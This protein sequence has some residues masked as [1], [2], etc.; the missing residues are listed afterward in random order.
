MNLS[1]SSEDD[2]SMSSSDEGEVIVNN[3]NNNGPKS[4]LLT[5][6]LFKQETKTKPIT[7]KLPQDPPSSRRR[8][9]IFSERLIQPI[10]I[11]LNVQER[12]TSSNTPTSTSTTTTTTTTFQKKTLKQL[13]NNNDEKKSDNTTCL[14]TFHLSLTEASNQM[15]GVEQQVGDKLPHSLY[16]QYLLLHA[17]QPSAY[18]STLL[19]V[20]KLDHLPTLKLILH[21]LGI[22]Y[23]LR[24]LSKSFPQNRSIVWIAAFFGASKVLDYFIDQCKIYI[25]Q[26]CLH[27]LLMES[28]YP[29]F[30][31]QDEKSNQMIPPPQAKDA[32]TSSSSS[33]IET[34]ALE[35]TRER[36][37]EELRRPSQDGTEPIMVAAVRNHSTIIRLLV[38]HGIK[39]T[40]SERANALANIASSFNYLDILHLLTEESISFFLRNKDNNNNNNND[41][42]QNRTTRQKQQTCLCLEGQEGAVPLFSACQNGHVNVVQYFFDCHQKKKLYVDFRQCDKRGF[43]CTAIAAFHDQENVIRYLDTIHDPLNTHAPDLNQRISNQHYTYETP[44]HLAVRY[45]KLRAIKAFLDCQNCNVTARNQQGQTILHIAASQ[46]L[47]EPMNLLVQT[48]SRDAIGLMDSEDITGSTPLYIASL[49]GYV[50]MVTLLAPVSDISNICHVSNSKP[51]SSSIPNT[52]QPALLI[53]TIKNYVG[54]VST[55]LAA[56]ADVDARDEMGHT[57]IGIAARLGYYEMCE[58]LLKHGAD[59]TLQSKKGGGTPLQKAKRYRK[60]NIVELLQK[61]TNV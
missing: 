60:N 59:L 46:N 48:L 11:P 32:D 6:S 61:Y 30:D 16:T 10:A 22:Q 14:E 37:L 40:N 2:N 42:G 23:I 33:H 45:S 5:S 31:S 21:D 12:R 38:R 43:S 18:Q 17:G 9:S 8:K 19:H 24:N 1:V 57:A 50:E 3:N 7:K 41:D 53:A 13:D 47:I 26:Q 20:I 28:N 4:S 54:V 29:T 56:G 25:Y 55:L 51:I 52:D 44:L 35:M 39:I 15:V 34:K 36:I 27:Q 58:L 49:A